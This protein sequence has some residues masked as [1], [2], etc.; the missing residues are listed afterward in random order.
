MQVS[1]VYT[2]APTSG[3]TEVEMETYALLDRLGIPYERVE[4]GPANTME[5]CEDIDKTL[6]TRI[7]KNLFLCNRQKTVFYLLSMPGEKPFQTKE[8]SRPSFL[9]SRRDD[10]SAAA[11][12][13]RLRQRSGSCL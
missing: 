6:G 2:T 3:R 9:R 8:L 13:S 7:C 11:L 10:G 1:E 12:P 5:D 4:H